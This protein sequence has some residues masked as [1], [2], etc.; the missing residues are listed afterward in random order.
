MTH[1]ASCTIGCRRFDVNDQ[2]MFAR[3]SGDANPIHVDAVAARRSVLRDVVVHGVHTVIWALEQ[4]ANT[5][6]C[7]K[8]ISA[9]DVRFPRPIYLGSDVVLR[10][11]SNIGTALHLIAAVGGKTVVS[12]KLESQTL[13]Q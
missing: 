7:P 8:Q 6:F 5:P 11:E 13:P 4:L 3:L 2:A 10:L 12:I 9:L 1:S